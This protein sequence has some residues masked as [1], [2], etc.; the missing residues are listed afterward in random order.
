MCLLPTT[1]HLL[2][3]TYYHYL[4]PSTKYL[5]PATYSYLLHYGTRQGFLMAKGALPCATDLRTT[6]GRLQSAHS[7]P[8]SLGGR[9][10]SELQQLQGQARRSKYSHR[11]IGDAGARSTTN[12]NPNPTPSSKYTHGRTGDAGAH[13]NP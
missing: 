4:L 8:A 13:S 5:L 9:S 1:F 11:R 12:P 6:L 7:T 10:A 2:P 3:T